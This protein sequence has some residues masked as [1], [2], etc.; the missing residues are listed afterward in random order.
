M[1]TPVTG[2]VG[3]GTG[4]AQVAGEGATSTSVARERAGAVDAAIGDIRRL[5]ASAPLS[6]DLLDGVRARLLRLAAQRELFPRADFPAPPSSGRLGSCLYRLSQDDDD[7]F[8]LYLN[9]CRDRTD[10]PAHDHTTWA[11]VVGFAGEELNR[12]Y[13]RTATGEGVE[14]THHEVVAEGTGVT[15]LPDDLHSIHI[16]GG[17]LNFH[18]YGLALE[19]LDDRRFFRTEDATWQPFPAHPDIREARGSGAE[20]TGTAPR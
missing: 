20:R 16:R 3:A 4:T 2:T 1:A 8:A 13:R 10:S 15:M 7:R 17:G 19:R 18:L 5:V 14:E 12:F 9:V 6:R 11:V